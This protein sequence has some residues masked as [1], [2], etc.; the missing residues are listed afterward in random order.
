VAGGDRAV[1]VQRDGLDLGAAE[2]DPDADT[3]LG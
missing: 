2:V 3:W 1:I